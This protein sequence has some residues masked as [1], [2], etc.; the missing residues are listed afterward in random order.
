MSKVNTRGHSLGLFKRRF[1]LDVGKYGFG[2][3]VCDDWN[4]LTEDVVAA[5]TLL[6]FKIR[7]DRYLRKF[8]G[9]IQVFFFS[10]CW[11]SME[12]RSLW[13]VQR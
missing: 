4:A 3:R 11:P 9:F 1:K 10:L 12:M 2:N 6:N 13:M 7:L 5:E 8:R